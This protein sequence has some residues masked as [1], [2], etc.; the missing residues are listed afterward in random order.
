M[1]I[2][3]EK[4]KVG[5]ETTLYMNRNKER[6]GKIIS[7]FVDIHV[8]EKALADKKGGIYGQGSVSIRLGLPIS[9]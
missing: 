9:Q 8:Q 6:V 5:L 1:S 4:K 3:D 7:G 2:F